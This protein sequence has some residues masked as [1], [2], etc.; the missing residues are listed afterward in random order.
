MTITFVEAD[1][2]HNGL[3]DKGRQWRITRVK[4]GWRLHF[5][6]AG[7]PT[8]VNA[9]VYATLADAQAAAG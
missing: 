4:T 1:G 3:G 6:D 2:G 5:R 8:P 7:D 9:G